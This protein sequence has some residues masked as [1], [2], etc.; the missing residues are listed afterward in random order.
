MCVWT[1]DHYRD[2]VPNSSFWVTR[3][4]FTHIQLASLAS[5]LGAIGYQHPVELR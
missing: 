3:R 4:V 1:M 5:G 2:Q